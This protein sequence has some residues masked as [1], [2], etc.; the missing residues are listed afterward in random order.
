MAWID[1]GDRQGWSADRATSKP[2][3]VLVHGA[4]ADSSSW[5]GVVD[6]CSK[7]VTPVGLLIRCAGSQTLP[8]SLADLGRRRTRVLW[9]FIRRRRDNIAFASPSIALCSSMRR[10]DAGPTVERDARSRRWFTLDTHIR[11]QWSRPVHQFQILRNGVCICGTGGCRGAVSRYAAPARS[12]LHNGQSAVSCGME[13]DSLLVRHRGRRQ[14]HSARHPAQVCDAC[15][16][17]DLPRSRR[18]PS[19]HDRAP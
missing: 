8:S 4:W 5:N 10:A 16:V 17:E 1:M 7:T 6:L 9:P 2:T 3:I 15:Q 14:G 13:D 18:R 19:K 12:T 11:R